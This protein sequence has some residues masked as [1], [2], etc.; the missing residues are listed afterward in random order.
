MSSSR[1][2][3]R[4]FAGASIRTFAFACAVAFSSPAAATAVT[5]SA[6]D[7]LTTFVGPHSTSLDV[8][9]ASVTFSN[10]AFHFSATL[11]GNADGSVANTAYVWGIDRGAGTAILNQ[12]ATPVGAGVPFDMVAVIFPNGTAIL[13]GIDKN[14][15]IPG[16]ATPLTPT[17]SGNTM[18]VDIPVS[19]L[20]AT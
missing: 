6:N 2:L 4:N 5:D 20:P 17:I 10:S 1:L 15:P 8:T 14:G 13:T 9:A 18:T 19:L 7:F 12:G 11:A 3:R 16:T